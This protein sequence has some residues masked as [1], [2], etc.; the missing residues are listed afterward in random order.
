MYTT[1]SALKDA[2]GQIKTIL[3]K[4]TEVHSSNKFIPINGK[5]IKFQKT[6]MHVDEI[7]SLGSIDL[8][9]CGLKFKK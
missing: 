9:D 4:Y 7:S 6:L 2:I 1:D 5:E 3:L 8:L